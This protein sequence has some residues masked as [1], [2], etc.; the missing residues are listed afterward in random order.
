MTIELE[1]GRQ[2][3]YMKVGVHAQEPLEDIIA[4][5]QRE[6]DD[7]GFSMWGYGGNT[8]HP[9]TMVRP[10]AQ[11]SERAG[12][13]IILCMQKMKSN[14]YAQQVRAN[15][16]STDGIDWNDIDPAINVLGSRYA[17]CIRDLRNV[18]ATIDLG[19]TAVALGRSAGRAG[20]AYI[21]GHV[22]KACLDVV[23]D[24]RGE[25]RVVQIDLLADVIDPYA[26]LLR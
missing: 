20:S 15:Q 13:R 18:V 9:I 4:R 26:V 3:L 2:V 6:I 14:H 7:A 23:G 25:S 17:L 10:F 19:D 22:D 16:F 11:A 8:C 1:P 5:K 21:Q 24:Q 12:R